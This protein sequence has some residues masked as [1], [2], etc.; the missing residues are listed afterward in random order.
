MDWK[1]NAPVFADRLDAGRQLGEELQLR[2]YG[3][4]PARVL[5]IPRGGVPVG[6]VVAQT[7]GAPL[8]IIIPGKLPV[9]ND[10]ETSFGAITPDGKLFL[11]LPVVE[12][13]QSDPEEIKRVAVETLSKVRCQMQAYGGDCLPLDLADETIILVDDGLNTGFTMLVAVRA[14]RRREA[15]R[16]VVAV[17]VGTFGATDR[18]T[19]QVDDLACLVEQD[20][21]GFA[22]TRAYQD[23]AA[24]SD[25]QVLAFLQ[26]AKTRRRP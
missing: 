15:A 22:I 9:P 25:D 14:V 10:P 8:G 4:E 5:A 13:L 26:N 24:L 20:S 18:L 21:T 19:P 2:G 7:I 23:F 11:N 3:D 12:R 6:Y 16:V 1:P 17:P